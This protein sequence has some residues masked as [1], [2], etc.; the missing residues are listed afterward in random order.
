MINNIQ[1]TIQ[2]VSSSYFIDEK[3]IIPGAPGQLVY[4]N[5]QDPWL[6]FIRREF[7]E[8]FYSFTKRFIDILVAGMILILSLPIMIITSC[9][10]KFD[11]PG[12]VFFKQIRIGKNRRNS[13]TKNGHQHEQRKENLKGKPFMMYKFRTMSTDMKPYDIKPTDRLDSRITRVGKFLRATCLDELPQIINVLKGDLSLVGP[14]PEMPFIVKNYNHLEALRLK[15]KPGITGLW[16]LYAPRTQRI[17]ENLQYDLYYLNKR[18][19]LF[20]IKIMF[21][22]LGYMV[23]LQNV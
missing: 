16:Q 1:A 7:P 9:L 10:I 17:H 11:S 14:R 20:D 6:G 3:S 22:T 18:S 21:M 15:V 12:P 13:S 4:R 8:E 23:R 19:L 5:F 2:R